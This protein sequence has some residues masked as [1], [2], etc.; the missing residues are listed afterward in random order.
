MAMANIYHARDGHQEAEEEDRKLWCRPFFK[1]TQ[2]ANLN[3]WII[4][5]PK[6]YQ[7]PQT[8]SIA[9]PEKDLTWQ[10]QV[11]DWL[12]WSVLATRLAPFFAVAPTNLVN[13]RCQKTFS[14]MASCGI[15]PRKW[16]EWDFFLNQTSLDI[17]ARDGRAPNFH[18]RMAIPNWRTWVDYELDEFLIATILP[19]VQFNRVANWPQ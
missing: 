8:C 2:L 7:I 1:N 16:G 10:T 3:L 4:N 9:H 14:K 5:H 6:N 19:A 15:T 13:L 17:A 11:A 12:L 18:M